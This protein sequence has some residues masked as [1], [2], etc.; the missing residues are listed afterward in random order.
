MPALEFIPVD[1]R[2]GFLAALERRAG[3]EIWVLLTFGVPLEVLELLRRE[4][5]P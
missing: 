1:W 5:E 3:G 2:K 4:F